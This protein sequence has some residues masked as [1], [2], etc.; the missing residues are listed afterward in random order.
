MLLELLV[1]IFATLVGS[2][3][4]RMRPTQTGERGEREDLKNIFKIEPAFPV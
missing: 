4:L 2:S 3:C 1:V